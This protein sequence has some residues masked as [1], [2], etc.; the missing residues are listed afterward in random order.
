MFAKFH[1]SILANYGK[2]MYHSTTISRVQNR[3]IH[4]FENATHLALIEHCP[5]IKRT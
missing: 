1:L 4:H 2:I 3:N 5:D